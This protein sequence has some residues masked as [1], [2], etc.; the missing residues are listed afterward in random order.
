M[1]DPS[2]QP[3][4]PPP[5]APPGA[6]P[7]PHPHGL[8]ALVRPED[9]P[10]TKTDLTAEDVVA[11]RSVGAADSDSSGDKS[12]AGGKDASGGEDPP[13]LAP[14]TQVLNT[15]PGPYGFESVGVPPEDVLLGATGRVIGDYELD[16]VVGRGGMGVVWKARQVTLNRT[17]ALKMLPGAEYASPEDIARFKS[18]AEAAASLDHPNI[19]PIY[20]VGRQGGRPFF[21]MKMVSGGSLI[22][23]LTEL[24]TRPRCCAA[25]MVK[26]ARAI[27]HAHQRGVLHR[28]LKPSN[29]LL[30]RATEG[31]DG[32][33]VYAV[34]PPAGDPGRIEWLGEPMVTDFGLAKLVGGGANDGPTL[35]GQAVGTPGFMSPEQAVA[36][37]RSVTT[38]ADV[39]GLGAVLYSL[40][41]GKPP[42]EGAVFV[43]FA[44]RAIN[45]DPDA[46]SRHNPAVDR[47]LE[48][49]VLKCLEKAPERRYG[50]AE[51]LAED[52]SRWLAGEPIR[53]RPLG[54]VGRLAKWT[55]RRPALAALAAVSAAAAA[56]MAVTVTAFN[57]ELRKRYDELASV[58]AD[59]ATANRS[60]TEARAV[61][62]GNA[63][64]AERQR[65]AAERN[66]AEAREQRTRAERN[67]ADAKA[68][69]IES[70]RQRAHLLMEYGLSVCET[71]DR[72]G[73]L[74]LA[75]ALAVAPRPGEAPAGTAAE[76]A[77][78]D[79]RFREGVRLQLGAWGREVL[80]L[81]SRLRYDGTF[82]AA[83]WAPDGKVLA[84]VTEDWSLRFWD[85]GNGKSV[86]VGLE[87][88]E[89]PSALAFSPD[90]RWLAVG[91]QSG[92][93]RVVAVDSGV[94]VG[95][96][97]ELGPDLV[98]RCLAFSPDGRRLAAAGVSRTALWEF[99]PDARDG[100]GA[101]VG[102]PSV[103][104]GGRFGFRDAGN[105]TAGITV[106]TFDIRAVR[107]TPDG[108]LLMT[109]G[110][111]SVLFHN[112]RDGSQMARS[113]AAP[114]DTRLLDSDIAPD[115][116]TVVTAG[117]DGFVRLWDPATGAERTP[118]GG[119]MRHDG[120]ATVAY[121]ADGKRI[122]TGGA[123]RTVRLWDAETG[124]R[125]GGVRREPTPVWRVG[126]SPDGSSAMVCSAGRT[127]IIDVSPEALAAT[128]PLAAWK[129]DGAALCV[130]ASPDGRRL[131][132]G[133]AGGAAALAVPSGQPVGEPLAGG[134]P[135]RSAAYSRDGRRL[136][137]S[138]NG[139]VQVWDAATL[140]P[141][142]RAVSHDDRD[143][144]VA[145]GPDERF[146]V[147][148]G[149][150]GVRFWDFDP[151]RDAAGA[152]LPAK[153]EDTEPRRLPAEWHFGRTRQISPA[154]TSTWSPD[155]LSLA[156]ADEAGGVEL[157]RVPP[158]PAPAAFG[159]DKR[160]GFRDALRIAAMAFS[161]DGRRLL[162]AGLDA[163]LKV[164]DA[165][166]GR[167][168]GGPIRF[169][170]P[171]TAAA[172]SPDGRIILGG[173]ADG[174]AR[175]CDAV[176]ARPLGGP[177]DQGG[178]GIRVTAAAFTP[179]ARLAVTTGADGSVRL[180]RV[181]RPVDDDAERVRLWAETLAG[182][183][184]DDA[185]V[186]VPLTE[187]TRRTRLERLAAL[188][189][190][191]LPRT[192]AAPASPPAEPRPVQPAQ[193]G[194]K[195]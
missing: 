121:S 72:A 148:A 189:G 178:D 140:R 60:A 130:A 188:G 137:T 163:T 54:P 141:L 25:L 117:S 96:T 7:H 27:H 95:R 135:V 43:Q 13:A 10:T 45:C 169:P 153:A 93:I 42:F 191:P 152:F 154:M 44:Y 83:A 180:W 145:F 112:A 6:Q 92:R 64:R 20:E 23:R 41:T 9:R 40:L 165:A 67:E 156:L 31:P 160:A 5:D 86:A 176:S 39:W 71:G 14:E 61:A 2:A 68:A 48:T 37:N 57:A 134:G 59:L 102:A 35:T 73:L 194:E 58:N 185:G 183:E 79:D 30:D 81:R 88:H 85:P 55:R 22:S 70:R 32:P 125:I 127:E 78:A 123:D 113:L 47:D 151:P 193:P 75:A 190:S 184:L 103:P 69:L 17:V 56:A 120:A 29:I 19:V 87:F 91:G 142:G 104:K 131:I 138:A 65:L 26:V 164:R 16:H 167:L 90:G 166:D 51:A 84:T 173:G 36:D 89:I 155:G 159:P 172:F 82:R 114:R 126:F 62:E 179:D 132:V 122:I 186:I 74:H 111:T 63:E 187:E 101:G 157:H 49:I 94:T 52:L 181:P 133:H 108:R 100:A 192:A 53:A 80:P 182:A 143:P 171:M 162:T 146:F 46:P 109:L 76:T 128:A 50:S 177:F 77:A 106:S 161:P 129:A 144:S 115:G 118:P 66:E 110:P 3:D 18:E 195:P 119:R 150:R 98:V 139:K 34:T 175:F 174:S 158:L 33:P 136:A 105:E 107:F 99:D 1:T 24:R 147:S 168:V 149:G 116:R 11:I 4:R 38:A 15:G 28:D 170:A 124:R 21:S 12:G 8:P 97:M